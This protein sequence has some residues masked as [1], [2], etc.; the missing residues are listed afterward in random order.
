MSWPGLVQK[1]CLEIGVAAFTRMHGLYTV[2]YLFTQTQAGS[3]RSPEA[4]AAS[5]SLVNVDASDIDR[6]HP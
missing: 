1:S 2:E 5:W 3:Q 4:E 6:F